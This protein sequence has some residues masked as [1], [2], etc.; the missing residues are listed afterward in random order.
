MNRPPGRWLFAGAI[1]LAL[2]AAAC[3]PDPTKQRAPQPVKVGGAAPAFTL[4]TP[5]GKPISLADYR[6][7]RPV[8]LYFSMGPG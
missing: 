8:L 6:D 1:T 3:G 7:R 2:I 4:K 5:E